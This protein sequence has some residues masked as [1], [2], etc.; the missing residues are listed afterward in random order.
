MNDSRLAGLYRLSVPERIDALRRAGWLS[1]GEADELK[2]GQQVL[3]A[4]GADRIIENVVGVFGLPFAVAP[5]FRVNDR[6]YM[7]PMVVEEPSIVAAVSGAAR[8]FR[9]SGGFAA[10]CEESLLA[11]QVHVTGVA[12]T[13]AALRQLEAEKHS[14][15]KAANAI[16]PRLS[17][18]GGGVRDLEFRLLELPGGDPLL[19]VH[20][21]VDT[22]DA[23]GANLVNTI[24]EAVAPEIARLCEGKV[25]LRILSNLVD[26]SVVTAGVNIAT[27]ELASGEAD[28]ERIRDAIIM[29]NDIACVDPHRAATHNKGIMNGVD[30]MAIATGN[31]WRAIE[32]GAHAFAAAGGTYQPLT[33]WALGPGGDLTGEVRIPLKVGTVGGT[34]EAN[35]AAAL[36]LGI[37]GAETAKELALLMASVGLAQNF[38]ALRALVGSGIQEGHMKLHARS[39][40]A[41]VNPPEEQFDELVL[42]LVDSGEI[43][44]WKAAEILGELQSSVESRIEPNGTAAGK[45]ILFGEHAAVYGRHALALPVPG[46]VHARVDVAEE[47]CTTLS[48]PAWDVSGQVDFDEPQGVDAAVALI[49][50]EL[51]LADSHFSIVV[52]SKLPRG[53]GLGSSAAVAVAVTRAMS[54]AMD[55]SV[56]DDRVNAIAFA[57][58]KLAHG[59]PSGVDNT[60]STFAQ[61]MLFRNDGG[62]TIEPLE[63]AEAPPLLVAYGNEVG[64]TNKQVAGVRERRAQSPGSYDAL[65]DE[66]DRMSVAGVAL[67]EARDYAELGLS[68]NICHGL[69]NALEVSTPGLERMVSLARRSGAVGAKLTGAGGGG[70]IIALCPGTMDKVRAAMQHAGYRTLVLER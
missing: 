24:C 39:I 66:M 31:D 26:R 62:L 8:L 50:D 59:T 14:L 45:V 60:L 6:D 2:A 69:L 9:K 56:G 55:L 25:A 38:A 4:S 28:G 54:K 43:K 48:I 51:D 63:L 53:M 65:F 20:V 12:D 37:S 61:P 52:D 49:R 35:P 21:L 10:H 29:A 64:L 27:T 22:V 68:M 19:V 42:R 3:L 30:A 44:R 11:G 7:V 5:N 16:H 70:S 18:R 1:P 46:A 41:A 32:A 23:M 33:R 34:L 36:G 58:E 47:S 15:L 17:A 67:L 57:C 40:A 13:D